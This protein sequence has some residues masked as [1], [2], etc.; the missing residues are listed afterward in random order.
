[1]SFTDANTAKDAAVTAF[2]AGDYDTARKKII[3]AMAHLNAMKKVKL[4]QH[5]SG[6]VELDIEFLRTLLSE[7]KSFQRDAASLAAGG[8]QTATVKYT[9]NGETT[10]DTY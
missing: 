9:R 2:E 5:A 6:E 10:D 4:D 8:I 3:V 1:M 7:I